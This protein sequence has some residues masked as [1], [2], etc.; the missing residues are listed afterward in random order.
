MNRK[1]LMISAALVGFAATAP[2]VAKGGMLYQLPL[3]S[4]SSE[5]IAFGVTDNQ[6]I[7]GY[8]LNGS[9]V[10]IG[11][12]GPADGSNYTSFND[13][14]T[15]GT[16]PRGINKKGYITGI[17]NVASGSTA[18][19]V[20]YE[21]SPDGTI[22][23]VTMDGAPLSYL[24]QGINKNGVFTGSYF[25]MSGNIHGYIGKKARYQSDVTLPGVTTT[26]VAGRGMNDKGD[27][28]GWYADTSGVQHGFLLS[29]GT[30][31]TID[32]PG[33]VTNLEGINNRGEISGLYTDTSGSRHG[34]VYQISTKTF[35]ELTLPNA[36]YV[37]AWGINDKGV[38]ALD[39]TN[40]TGVFIGYLYCP[41]ER[42][43]PAGAVRAET[44][45]V[46]LPHHAPVRS[47]NLP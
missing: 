39:G 25:D 12:V 8:S 7:T 41:K 47:P 6:T 21:R 20:P 16:Q 37:E 5:T 29:G 3:V 17:D 31:T 35:T 44:A 9:G 33:G 32:N 46:P 43:C 34:F 14:S 11:F 19:Y 40:P 4:G 26:A 13:D 28:V 38:V 45:R 1:A 27:I 22:T 42:D 2:A 30:T 15:G 10:E 18:D 23:D 36:T 24:I